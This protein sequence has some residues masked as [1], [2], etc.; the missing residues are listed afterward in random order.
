M[1]RTI[2]TLVKELKQLVEEK[3][4]LNEQIINKML[5]INA[6]V[7][8]EM[9]RQPTVDE[10]YNL[11]SDVLTRDKVR[12]YL[13]V[14]HMTKET[15][16]HVPLHVY[17][18]AAYANMQMT[19]PDMQ[20]KLVQ[21]FKDNQWKNQEFSRN[22]SKYLR[23]EFNELQDAWDERRH[24]L[25]TIYQIRSVE[26]DVRKYKN[27]LNDYHKL[28]LVHEAQKLLEYAQSICSVRSNKKWTLECSYEIRKKF[29][30]K[31]GRVFPKHKPI[32]LSTQELLEHNDI[33]SSH[34]IEVSP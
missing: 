21:K 22:P 17:T 20:K 4:K 7:T 31:I 13:S 8:R 5:E 18:R 9:N 2:K 1:S 14:R 19:Q 26:K 25:N 27:K 11:V 6:E 3:K 28:L 24:L 34:K 16:K 29:Q 23:K 32:Q 12:Y 30:Q 33:I 10:I 15:K